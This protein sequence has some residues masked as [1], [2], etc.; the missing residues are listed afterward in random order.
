MRH[1]CTLAFFI[2]L[3]LLL[4][5][6]SKKQVPSESESLTLTES[7]EEEKPKK[8][9]IDTP[10]ENRDAADAVSEESVSQPLVR[11]GKEWKELR[12]KAQ[13]NGCI[14]SVAF[15]GTS[16]DLEEGMAGFLASEEAEQYLDA[17]PGDT[18]RRSDPPSGW[19]IRGLLYRAHRSGG[20]CSSQYMGDQ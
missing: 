3:M 5:A 4:T 20:F 10:A 9:V 17:Y 7:R 6:C 8:G 13:E 2:I 19:W 11:A 15:L 14:C 1:K 18:G 16:L 12:E